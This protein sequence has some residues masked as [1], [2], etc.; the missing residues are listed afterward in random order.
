MEVVMPVEVPP[1]K[2]L[3]GLT[4]SVAMVFMFTMI[5]ALAA[6]GFPILRQLVRIV[7]PILSLWIQDGMNLVAIAVGVLWKIL[8]ITVV[9]A[10]IKVIL[11]QNI[12][13]IVHM[14]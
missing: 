10:G 6:L 9:F 8:T 4:A 12:I 13:A 1:T 5:V 14:V 2:T 3:H 11:N 7:V